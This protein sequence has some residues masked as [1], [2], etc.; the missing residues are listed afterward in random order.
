M[1]KKNYF[2]KYGFTLAEVLI[3]LGVV[4]VVSAITIPTLI[5]NYQKQVTVTQL[6][7]AYSELS[8]AIKKAEVEHEIME[9]WNFADFDSAIN[10]ATYFAENYIF[11]NVKVI[12]KCIPSSSECWVDNIKDLK[13]VELATLNTSGHISFITPSG[14]SVLHWLHADGTGGFFY[15]DINGPKKGPNRYGRDIFVM[16]ITFQLKDSDRSRGVHLYGNSKNIETLK[17]NCNKDSGIGTMCA[18]LIM[19]NGWKIKDDY[20]W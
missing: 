15:V 14:F 9:T 16:G 18:E 3:T 1:K 2:G 12:K 4:G 17:Q 8:Q 19:R 11:P 10:R 5:R 6:K 20:P 13:N 7:K